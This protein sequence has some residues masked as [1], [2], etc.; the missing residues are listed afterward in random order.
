MRLRR[1]TIRNVVFALLGAAV[2]V[3]ERHWGGTG[4][5]VV[6]AYAGNAAASLALYFAALNAMARLGRPRL[7]DVA[8]SAVLVRAKRQEPGRRP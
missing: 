1:M 2:L 8:S 3:L 7:A 5:D 4:E 6:H